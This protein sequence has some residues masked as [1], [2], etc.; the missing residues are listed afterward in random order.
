M[1]PPTLKE[2]EDLEDDQM[3]LTGED[4]GFRTTNLTGFLAC[5]GDSLS[6]RSRFSGN[7][8]P[9]GNDYLLIYMATC[10][11]GSPIAFSIFDIL[12]DNLEDDTTLRTPYKAVVTSVRDATGDGSV[13]MDDVAELFRS[14]ENE[15]TELE[16]DGDFRSRECLDLMA[17]Q[18]SWANPSQ[19]SRDCACQ[20][21]EPSPRAPA[22]QRMRCACHC[23]PCRRR[24]RCPTRDALDTS[25]QSLRGRWSRPWCRAYLREASF[26]P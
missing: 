19:G 25:L 12:D 11:T 23:W 5:D 24:C 18:G 10:Y 3:V 16:G 26:H 17:S 15:L 14:H 9:D 8:S 22:S 1:L 4:G 21:R 6:I 2:A 7:M 13:T 20:R